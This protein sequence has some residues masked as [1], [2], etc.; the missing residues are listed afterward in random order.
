MTTTTVTF[1]RKFLLVT[2][3][4]SL[5]SLTALAAAPDIGQTMQQ[6]APEAPP[7]PKTDRLDLQ[8]PELGA[9]PPPG[10]PKIRLLRITFSGNSVFHQ[11]A[12]L[13]VLGDAL[14]QSHDL[15]ALRALARRIS[16]HY[17]DHGYPFARAYLPEQ[18]LAT[19]ELRIVILEG[20][21][22]RVSAAGEGADLKASA[23]AFLA[24]LAP[25]AVIAAR[26]LE[27]A[28][29]LLSDQP[30][31]QSSPLIRPGEET[32]SGDLIV[33]VRRTPSLSGSLGI[34]NHGNRYTGANRARLDVTANSPFAF[35]D[36]LTF[37]AL[38]TDE[39]MWYGAL[40]YAL[41]LGA[42]GLRAQLS[43][44]RTDY[45]IGK[46]FARLNA[47]GVADTYSAGLIYALLRSQQTNLTLGI[48]V[49]YKD[50]ADDPGLGNPVARKNSAG[51][52]VSLSFDQRDALGVGGI[53]F[54]SV[55]W[56]HG[57][58]DLDAALA[59]TDAT[60]AR[61]V[62]DFDKV[63]LDLARLQNLPADFSLYGRASAQWAGK[64]LD[65]SEGFGIGGIGG[66]RAYPSG[67]GY[68]DAGWLAQIEVRYNRDVHLS[69]YAFYDAG[70]STTNQ[71]PWVDGNNHR[72]LA[73]AGLGVRYNTGP[74]TADLSAAWRVAGGKPDADS[75]D[76]RPRLWASVS[77]RR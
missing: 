1:P 11:E 68:G 42:D 38:Y 56:T 4:A 30:G 16:Q 70:R 65:S 58:L 62:G 21:Y 12:L 3:L 60:S 48:S 63:T 27:R 49:A 9:T 73:G 25:G 26:E 57:R 22:G 13:A 59:A 7:L 23:Q 14:E 36:R 32:G 61:T 67:E 24:P 29:L 10:G 66:V 37:A 43:Y 19:G 28:T 77:Y 31:I 75:R 39:A 71:R 45:Q 8:A 40:G 2:A 15:A 55:T 50:L 46:D 33:D 5:F 64:N 35:G 53:T 76:D 72:N 52:P 34:D 6:M 17:R 47:S 18:N 69:P 74:W 54:G 20:R 44:A 41:P 51:V